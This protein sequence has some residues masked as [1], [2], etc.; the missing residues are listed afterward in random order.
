MLNCKAATT[1]MSATDRLTA[2]AGD[3]LSSEDAT[4]YRSLVGGLQ[5]LTITCPDLS[6]AINRVCQFLHPPRDSH[7]TAVK[8]ILHYL[9]HTA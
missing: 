7:I 8:R 1:P 4:E 5:Y 9:C 3:L 6:Y 2:L